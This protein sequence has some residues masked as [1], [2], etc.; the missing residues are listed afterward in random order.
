MGLGVDDAR[1]AP[2]R[3]RVGRLGQVQVDAMASG[4]ADG[5]HGAEG[6]ELALAQDPDPV[7]H[8][9]DLGK[10]VRRQEYGRSFVDSLFE[11]R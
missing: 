7:G 3:R 6:D 8:A 9:L 1:Q 2:E 11:Q 5:V 4:G 10:D